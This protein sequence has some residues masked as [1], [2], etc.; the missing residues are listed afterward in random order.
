MKDDI[1]LVSVYTTRNMIVRGMQIPDAFLTDK[2]CATDDFKEYEKVF[3]GEKDEESYA[4]KFDASMLHDDVD[5]FENRIE[6]GSHKEHPEHVVDDD[7]NEEEKKDDKMGSLEN[8]TEKMQ[9]PI[10]TPPRS[11][12]INL[13]SDKIIVQ[14][15][16]DTDMERKCVTLDEFWKVHGK[17]DQVL[18]EIIPQLTEKST[19]DLIE[20][21]VKRAMVDTVIQERDAFQSKLPT[22]F[23]N[24]FDAQA[25]NVTPPKMRVAAESS[26]IPLSRESF[27]VIVE[28]DWLSKN[29]AVIM[30]H[31]KVVEIPIKEG[32]ILRVHG[33]HTLGA[34]KALT[35]A[36]I[37]ETKISDI[38]VVRNFTD[39]FLKD[40]VPGATLVA[41]S[42]YRL[43][44]SEM[45]ELSGQLQEL[46]DKGFI[47]P[48]HSSWGASVL[49][50][51]KKDVSFRMYI[52]YRELNKITIKNCFPLPMIDDLFD[53]LQGA[54]YFTKI[55]LRSRY[56]QLCTKEE[57]EVHLKLVLELLRKEKLYAK[58]SKCEFWL[59]EVHF[60]GHVVNQSGIHIDPSKL[61]AIKNWKAPTTPS[62]VRSFLGF[63][64]YY[65]HFIMNLSKIAKP[66]TSLT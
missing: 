41:K 38:P 49:F 51:K 47:R 14:E 63:A 53:Q 21:N 44:P 19:N 17:V 32:G 40:L 62:E 3:E 59:Q 18:L 66:L 42:L 9:I 34:A 58:F 20:G 37:Y 33:E 43:A 52:D 28:M 46:Q 23:S 24:E 12:R 10:P 25:P 39:V 13:S 48:S 35:N 22:L 61:E 60:L 6:P 64:G 5:D 31:E 8:R 4:S 30:C 15:L 27:D 2:I 65:R 11:P 54:C 56:H 26:L 50:V 29:E 16:T 1:S 45:Q 7:E 55:D 57:H 36:K